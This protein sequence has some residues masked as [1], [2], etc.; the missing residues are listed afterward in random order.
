M[1]IPDITYHTE[2]SDFINNSTVEG[3]L[4]ELESAIKV[5]QKELLDPLMKCMTTEN[6]GL[7]PTSFNIEGETILTDKAQECKTSFDTIVENCSTLKNKILEEAKNHRK[8]EL[9]KLIEC[10]EGRIKELK[11]I[12]NNLERKIIDATHQSTILLESQQLFYQE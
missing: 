2:I 9:E 11:G 12:I 6:G 3:E 4:S 10:V 1:K 7:D 8:E 5:I